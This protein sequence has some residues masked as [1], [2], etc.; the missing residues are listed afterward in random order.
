MAHN[1]AG[2]YAAKH[3]PERKLDQNLARAVKEKT[4][5]GAISC[6]AAHMIANRF[7]IPPGEVGFTV[8]LLEIRIAKCQLGLFGYKPEG[9]IVKSA[10]T[11]SDELERSIRNGLTENRLHCIDA[12]EIADKLGLKLLD[13]AS[14]CEGMKIKISK[15]QLGAF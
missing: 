11:I 1:D 5:D 10:E 13:V 7:K 6:A 9:R 4:R 15:C 8:D 2:H 12:W 3:S 14:A